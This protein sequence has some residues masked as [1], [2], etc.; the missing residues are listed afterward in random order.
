MTKVTLLGIDI[1][2]EIFQLHGITALGNAVLRKKL[3]R[4]ELIKFIANLE[5]CT[6]VME[7]CGGSHYWAR[8]FQKFE[9]EVK[10]ISPQYVKPFVHGNKNDRNDAEAIVE[11][12][13]RPRT[14]FVPINDEA[15]QDIRCVHRIRSRLVSERTTLLMKFAGYCMNMAFFIPKVF[16]ILKNFWRK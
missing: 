8:E 9:H 1:A 4:S 13:S 5:P 2:K 10:L 15:E 14:R 11:A 6:I 12:A 16:E 7:T 3:K